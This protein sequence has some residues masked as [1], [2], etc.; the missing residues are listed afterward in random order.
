MSKSIFSTI[1]VKR[2]KRSLFNLSHDRKFS[3]PL[4]R[5]VPI[6]CEEVN[7]GDKWSVHSNFVIRFAPMIAPLMHNIDV[8]VHYFYVPNRIIWSGW[9]EFITGGETGNSGISLPQISFNEMSEGYINF[10]NKGGHLPDYLG[11]ATNIDKTKTSR[12]NL[13]QLPFRAYHLIWLDYFRDENLQPLDYGKTS[14]DYISKNSSATL[15]FN[16][17]FFDSISNTNTL[18]PSL[19]LR[20]S[21]YIHDYFTSA[22]PWTQR[23]PSASI[24]IS[25]DNFT[26]NVILKPINALSQ[27]I[28][29]LAPSGSVPND[30]STLRT[31][32]VPDSGILTTTDS[33]SPTFN[34]VVIDPNGTL[35][36]DPDNVPD[37]YLSILD[38]RRANALQRWLE[39]NARGGSRL[40]E[41]I[42]NHFG[43]H[44]P[45]ARLQ[46]PEF[47]GG[48]KVPVNISEVLQTSE[49]TS[50]SPQGNPSGTAVAAGTAVGFSNKFFSEHGFVMGI[51]SIM[52]R[53]A[54]Q[55]G[56]RRFFR[57]FNKFD[58]YWPEFSHIGEQEIY[59]WELYDD[60]DGT[61][62][63][64]ATENTAP[65]GYTPRYS[66]FKFIPDSVHGDFKTSLSF[67]HGARIFS[68]RPVLNKSFLFLGSDFQRV[69]AVQDSGGQ[70]AWC[71]V[72]NRVKASRLMPH[73]GVPLI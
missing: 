26:Q 42:Y 35:S 9:E 1:P 36:T 52:P 12:L 51:M 40:K 53:P 64:V 2:P 6:L 5:L 16:S 23:G 46:R 31:S 19:L 56:T 20:D 41:T 57:K 44:V 59:N 38:F 58:Y 60:F 61:T 48:G 33:S 49:T 70:Q 15:P 37:G 63:P 62:S 67:W 29:R 66:E 43:V 68:S 45:D 4:G 27:Q 24:P 10:W 13:S 47:L 54:Y 11:V 17:F 50:S 55:Q 18:Y 7:P 69:F 21:N 73:F 71:W 65:F 14:F 8:F 28:V 39:L 22:L 25:F 3:C 34:Q 30:Q 32:S 72:Y